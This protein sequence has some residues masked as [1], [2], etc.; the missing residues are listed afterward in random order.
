[1]ISE[2]IVKNVSAEWATKHFETIEAY[3]K[4]YL[5]RT[6]SKIEDL[7][8]V[9]EKGE[10]RFASLRTNYY[11]INRNKNHDYK[12]GY[13]AGLSEIKKMNCNNCKHYSNWE[14]EEW[15]P[16][17]SCANGHFHNEII[18]GKDKMLCHEWEGKK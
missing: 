15:A 13:Q 11:L 9:K 4:E 10:A 6:G 16:R 17:C 12:M 18:T 7:C 3:I 14:N 1:M 8:L 2:E 5:E